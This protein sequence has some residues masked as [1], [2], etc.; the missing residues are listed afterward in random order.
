MLASRLAL[1][2]PRR[3]IPLMEYSNFPSMVSKENTD[4]LKD[5]V[6]VAIC[7]ALV[8]GSGKALKTVAACGF[9]SSGVGVILDCTCGEKPSF[10]RVATTAGAYAVIG[11]GFGCSFVMVARA[12]KA[13][14]NLG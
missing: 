11:A 5:L 6:P 10:H 1:S 2:K 8:Q 13:L 12:A 4:A 9:L 3:Q 14:R 7:L